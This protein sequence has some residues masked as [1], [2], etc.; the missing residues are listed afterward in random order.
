MEKEKMKAVLSAVGGWDADNKMTSNTKPEGG[1]LGGSWTG[2]FAATGKRRAGQTLSFLL[3]KECQTQYFPRTVS[4]DQIY[5]TT[6][7][8]PLVVHIKDEFQVQV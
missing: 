4:V 8:V 5:A 2:A 6:S 7:F 1:S 3:R